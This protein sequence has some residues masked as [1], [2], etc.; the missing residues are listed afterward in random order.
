[1]TVGPTTP[2]PGPFRRR[3][4]RNTAA[5]AAANG[6][7]M[8]LSL[9]S[10]PFLLRGL[11]IQAFGVWALLQSFSA[12]TGWLSLADLGVGLA[13]TRHI[14][15]HASRD[16]VDAR[17]RGIATTLLLCSTIGASF[18]LLVAVIG[19]TVFPGA[20]NVPASLENPARFA[21]LVFSG[22]ALFELIAGGAGACLDGLQRVDLSRLA[23]AGRRTLVVGAAATTALLGGG[24]PGVAIAATSASAVGAV[25]ALLL[26]RRQVSHIPLRFDRSVARQLLRYGRSV[27]SLNVSGV[28]HRT[29][30]R[31][32]VGVVLGPAAVALVEIA[33]QVQNG[34]AAVLGAASYTVAS[35]AAW[36]HGLGGP[37]RL[38][39]LVLR[40]SRYACLVTLP[41]C[42]LVS[43]LAAPI[44]ATWLGPAYGDAADLVRLALLYVATQAALASGTNVLVGTGRAARIVRPAIAAVVTNLVASVVLVRQ[45]GVAGAFVATLLSSIVLVPLLARLLATDLGVRPRDLL[46]ESVLPALAPAAGA[47]A[48]GGL[49]LLT[50][51]PPAI[52]L[53]VGGIGGLIAAGLL[54]AGF[55]LRSDERRELVRALSR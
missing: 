2:P 17:D 34:V 39:Q 22:Q 32:V 15:D 6:W 38:R 9:A 23:D 51:W 47:A 44:I 46:R 12:V 33:T 26:L 10:V 19:P 35:G 43:T 18:A 28:L 36:L 5:T 14:A 13:A 48:I 21:V 37:E 25:F 1:M 7:T 41:L 42:A 11:G 52:Q 50:P 31:L 54:A 16:D 3:L 53:A 8:V 30:D 40:A 4:L 45:F 20:F 29:M 24:L 27:W 49:A 55:S